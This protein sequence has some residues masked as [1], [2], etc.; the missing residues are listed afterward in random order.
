MFL[1]ATWSL[2]PNALF[3]TFAGFIT[4]VSAWVLIHYV[5]FHMLVLSEGYEEALAMIKSGIQNAVKSKDITVPCTL[6]SWPLREPLALFIWIIATA[7]YEIIWRNKP[8]RINL[9]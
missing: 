8:L 7:G 2:P 3:W 5:Q 4:H 9:V 1:V 6:K